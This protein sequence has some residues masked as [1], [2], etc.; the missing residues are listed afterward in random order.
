[1]E[2]F[3][4]RRGGDWPPGL[5]GLRVHDLPAPAGEGSAREQ[6]ALAVNRALRIALEAAGRF[7]FVYERYS[8][9]SFAGM[10]YARDRRIPGLLEVNAPLVDEQ[11][12]FRELF[13]VAAAEAAATRAFGAASR[14]LAVSDEVASHLGSRPEARGRIEVVANG[15]DTQRFHPRLR[16]GRPETG[17]FTVGFVG[18]LKAWHGLPILVQAF[19]ELCRRVP[20]AR[21]LVVGDGPERGRLLAVLS[22]AGVAERARLTGAVDP[23]R[24]PELV[25]SMDAAVAP[26]PARGP[27]YFSPLTVDESRAGG[28]PVVASRIP[29]LERLVE[30]G[31]TG[32][33]VEPG[34]AGQL[35]L[36]LERLADEPELRARLAQA[37]RAKVLRS[38][39][40]EAVGRRILAL[41]SAALKELAPARR[42]A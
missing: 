34:E 7:D 32:L 10:E 39:T 2:L 23:A 20:A 12:A 4:V 25:A 40:W 36:A 19:A 18:S 41:A 3:A 14:L 27:G 22:A 30:D 28:V 29:P 15:V 5:R 1:V 24:V 8:L 6:G 16:A 11:R 21:L 13:D 37:A 35:R 17:A 31:V 33:L 26:Y 9:W 42:R 38:G